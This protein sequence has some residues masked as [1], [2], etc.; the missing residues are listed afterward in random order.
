MKLTLIR[1]WPKA[2]YCVGQLFIDG[3]YFCDTLE[4]AVRDLSKE[5][6]VPGKTAIPAGTYKVIWTESPKFKRYLPRLVDVPNFTG[7]LIHPGNSN[8]DTEG[9][10]LVGKNTAPGRLTQSRTYSD[11]L[12]AFIENANKN[13]MPIYI[14]IINQ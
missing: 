4:D 3:T 6:K 10:I 9:C 1:K 11:R 14:D 12:N 8:A 5:P 7:I 2:D 13:K